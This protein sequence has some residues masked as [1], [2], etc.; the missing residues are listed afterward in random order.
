MNYMIMEIDASKLLLASQ[1][2]MKIREKF[3]LVFYK[4]SKNSNF[5]IF[6]GNL[7]M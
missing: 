5:Q 1:A 2:V 7:F 3:Y 4:Y 6:F